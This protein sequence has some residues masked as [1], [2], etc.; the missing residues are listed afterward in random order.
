MKLT[1]D[2]RL[3]ALGVT[4][5]ADPLS[6]SREEIADMLESIKEQGVKEER[7]Q[8]AKVCREWAAAGMGSDEF[9]DAVNACADAIE[10]PAAPAAQ[11]Q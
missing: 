2:Q 6:L 11:P 8:W 9:R 1:V 10:S 4:I 5:C 3:D 7:A